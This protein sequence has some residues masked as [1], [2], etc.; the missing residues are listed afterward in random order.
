MFSKLLKP[1]IILVTFSMLIASCSHIGK[2][3]EG[4]IEYNIE[5]ISNQT[6]VP[7]YLMPKT[8][9]LKYKGNRN[10]TSIEGF[11]GQFTITNIA[12]NKKQ[13]NTTL[14]KIIDNR[15]VSSEVNVYPCFYD[16]L[17]DLD[18][19]F[20]EDTLILAG[21]KSY[22]VLARFPDQKNE[23][24]EVYYTNL[25]GIEEPNRINPYN[26]IGGVLTQFNIRL[27]N[28][29]MKLV[30]KKHEKRDI[31]E[32]DFNIPD[33]YKPISNTKLSELVGQLLE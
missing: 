21:L 12:D 1:G 17:Q 28:I 30:A 9:T 6:S 25:I 27:Q 22:K 3:E 10:I 2:N 32:S 20:T 31:P 15:F 13:T 5:Y 8:L 7:T 24:F 23:T 14:L 29:E 19:V 11:M 33:G 16:G 4:I 26:K 18:F